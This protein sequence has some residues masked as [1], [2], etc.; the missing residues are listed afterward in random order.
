MHVLRSVALSSSWPSEWS[1]SY[2][3]NKP[4]NLNITNVLYEAVKLHRGTGYGRDTEP[5]LMRFVSQPE[6]CVL[7]PLSL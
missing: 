2:S 4:I 1:V 6:A 3:I 7:S 5:K